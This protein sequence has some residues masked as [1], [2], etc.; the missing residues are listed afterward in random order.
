MKTEKQELYRSYIPKYPSYSPD[1][2]GRD[3]YIHFN[4]GGMRSKNVHVRNHNVLI[5]IH[6]NF[7][8]LG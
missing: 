3:T 2:M 7:K 8:S 6:N 1:G 4:N 5:P